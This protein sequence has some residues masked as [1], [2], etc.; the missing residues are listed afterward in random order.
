MRKQH[1]LFLSSLLAAVL[2]LGGYAVVKA[3]AQQKGSSTAA[4][5]WSDPAT[6]PDKKVPAK[7]ALVTITKDM[8]VVMDVSPTLH[9][10]TNRRQVELREQ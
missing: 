3:Q 6:W 1:V 5:R 8:N 7:D 4:K 2:V 9:G 10:L